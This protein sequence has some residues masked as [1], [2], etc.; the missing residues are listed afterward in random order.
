MLLADTVAATDG[1]ILV[2]LAVI[3]VVSVE[4]K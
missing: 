2:L 3:K 1:L 4:F